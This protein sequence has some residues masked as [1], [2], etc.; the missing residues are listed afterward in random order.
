MLNILTNKAQLAVEEGLFNTGGEQAVLEYIGKKNSNVL[1]WFAERNYEL[2][3]GIIA[4]MAVVLVCD[5]G[6]PVFEDTYCNP[7]A[8]DKNRLNSSPQSCEI[9]MSE[10]EVSEICK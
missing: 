1:N 9:I 2:K 4:G 10:I 6:K 3:I 5:Q 7:G 8:P